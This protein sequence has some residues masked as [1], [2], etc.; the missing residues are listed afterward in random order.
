[1]RAFRSIAAIVLFACV[2]LFHANPAHAQQTWLPID[3]LPDGEVF[4]LL[5]HSDTLFALI[6]SSVHF[7]SHDNPN[8]Q[9][10]SPIPADTPP[11]SLN[12]TGNRL[13]VGTYGSGIFETTNLGLDWTP[14][15]TGLSG[16]GA[17]VVTAMAVRHDSIYAGTSGAG[18]FV[19]NLNGPSQWTTY[20]TGMPSLAGW[21]VQSLHEWSGWLFCGSGQNANIYINAPGESSWQEM[22]FGDFIPTGLAMFAIAGSGTDLIGAASNGIYTSADTGLSWNHFATPF[23]SAGDGAVASTSGRT[24]VFF[25]HASRGAYIFER[26]GD[27][28]QLFDHQLVYCYD[29]AAFGDRLYAARHD[30]LWYL[31]L[32]STDVGDSPGSELPTGVRLEQNYPNP[33]NPST[34]IS[35]SLR[36]ASPVRLAV[37]NVLGQSVRVV[38]DGFH[39]AGD[40]RTVWDGTDDRGR[41]VAGG[42]YFYRLA[43]ANE[44][45]SRKMLLIK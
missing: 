41:P 34:T 13:F 31:P 18:V 17:M 8:W 23:S 43:T 40:Y 7:R 28:W 11:S 29:L 10:S 14:R 37:Y 44:T 36:E 35:F 16:V 9:Q 4:A 25:M 39:S 30:G 45:K 26:T 15:T 24:F 3:E 20:R 6:D 19:M 12:K 27:T 38:L 22:P 1:M 21:D 33:F 2:A 5:V 32:S 42:V